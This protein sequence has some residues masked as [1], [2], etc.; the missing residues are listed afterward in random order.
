MGPVGQGG[1]G[2]PG[3]RRQQGNRRRHRPLCE[4]YRWPFGP[5]DLDRPL[6]SAGLIAEKLL[7]MNR[8]AAAIAIDASQIKGLHSCCITGGIG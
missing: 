8:G 7:G 5:A 3:K 6:P 4:D 2:P 1:G